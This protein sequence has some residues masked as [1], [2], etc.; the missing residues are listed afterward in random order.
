MKKEKAVSRSSHSNINHKFI[1]QIKNEAVKTKRTGRRKEGTVFE[2]DKVKARLARARLI[3]KTI[4][5]TSTATKANA[6]SDTITAPV[7]E[8]ML[9]P[10]DLVSERKQT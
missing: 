5:S 9:N 8:L 4:V 10:P 3:T 1:T 6:A 2:R 7:T